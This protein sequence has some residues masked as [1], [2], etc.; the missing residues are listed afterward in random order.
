MTVSGPG[1]TG[2]GLLY[3]ANRHE[4]VVSGQVHAIDA[5][6]MDVEVRLHNRFVN[7]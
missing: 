2:S 3:R 7:L 1:N 4:N 6:C 5:D